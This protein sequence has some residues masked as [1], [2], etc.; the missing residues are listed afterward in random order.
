MVAVN[1]QDGVKALEV[2]A[3]GQLA[4]QSIPAK[5]SFQ[6]A[7]LAANGSLGTWESY[8]WDATGQALCRDGQFTK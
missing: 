8:L 1:K 7:E 6:S 3:L 5:V 4:T 2:E